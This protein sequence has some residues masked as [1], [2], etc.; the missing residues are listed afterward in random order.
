MARTDTLNRGAPLVRGRSAISSLLAM[1]TRPLET[2]DALA[3]EHGGVVELRIPGQSYVLVCEPDVIEQVLKPPDPD[4][5]HKG[6]AIQRVKRILG[7]G[8][9]T[10]DGEGY[11]RRRRLAQPAFQPRRLDAY[12][13]A[14]VRHARETCDAID[15]GATTDIERAM[16]SMAL[17]VAG[18][19]MF[20]VELV[21]EREQR[22]HEALAVV[23]ECFIPGLHPLAPML[24]HLPLPIVRR[25]ERAKR[26]LVATVDWIIAAR[27]ADPAADERTDLLSM[28]L[29]ARDESGG[30]LSDR[31]L[32]DE[33]M[34]LLL[35]GHETTANALA[36]TCY[37]LAANPGAQAQVHAQVA[38][39]L[40]DRTEPTAED[41]DRLEF[42]RAA[43]DESLRLFPSGS[44]IARR[45][46]DPITLEWT[47]PAGVERRAEIA[48]G[49][50]FMLSQWV[51]Q[52]DRRWY[53]ADVETFRPERML[54]ADARTRHRYSFVA[55]GGGRRVCIGRAFARQQATIAIS[56][57]LAR[58]ALELPP[59]TDPP[60]RDRVEIGFT[61][62]P[63]G[64]MHLVAQSR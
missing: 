34:V 19:A 13:E 33:A 28:L 64:G 24:E 59:G 5:M 3:V 31:E 4:R 10:A 21:G 26:E 9:L 16:D 37:L 1:R 8:L 12:V 15:A 30:A 43:F 58:F 41:L 56:M 17:R 29:R 52:H 23:R 61:L 63:L 50:E 57:L 32:R 42:V 11:L 49:S 51:P 55:F 36:W 6:Q 35:A 39:V 54:D 27:R 47:D 40:G 2:M 53:G 48:A 14:M 62:R 46:L 22:I 38:E 7:D 45:T 60:S 44:V 25:F 18:E 20:G